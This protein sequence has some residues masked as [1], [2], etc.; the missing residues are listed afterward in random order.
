M[1]AHPRRDIET[2]DVAHTLAPVF[3]LDEQARKVRMG[4]LWEDQPAV[5]FFIRYF[6]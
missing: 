6:G 1:N 4:T 5:L 2:S 3:A